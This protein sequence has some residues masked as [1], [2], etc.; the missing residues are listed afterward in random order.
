MTNPIIVVDEIAEVI[1][2]VNQNI[3]PTIAAYTNNNPINYQYGRSILINKLLQLNKNSIPQKSNYPLIALFQDF[4]E[5]NGKK[6]GYIYVTIPKIVIATITDFNGTTKDRY[7][8]TFKPILYPIYNEFIK[9]LGMQQSII[10]FSPN[11][12]NFIKYDRP[13]TQPEGQATNDYIDAI[14]IENLQLTFYQPNN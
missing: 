14:T 3:Y 1:S 12:S 5:D 7:D 10:G 6:I 13:G 11:R 9:Q 4:P 8:K 2:R